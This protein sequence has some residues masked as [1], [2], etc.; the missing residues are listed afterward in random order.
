MKYFLKDCNKE[1]CSTCSSKKKEEIITITI[2]II[3][4]YGYVLFVLGYH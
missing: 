4:L 3:F 1:H 2:N